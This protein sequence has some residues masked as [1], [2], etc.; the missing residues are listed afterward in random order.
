MNINWA[1]IGTVAKLIA[2]YDPEP[3]SREAFSVI[4][5]AAPLIPQIEPDVQQLYADAKPAIDR[6]KAAILALDAQIGGGTPVEP[7]TVEE[8]HS[9]ALAVHEWHPSFRMV[10]RSAVSIPAT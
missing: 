10:G 5:V 4:G 8:A 1:L 3:I 9:A 7:A 2:T 6:A